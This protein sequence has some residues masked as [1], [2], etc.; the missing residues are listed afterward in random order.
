MK[1]SQKRGIII[2]A[3]IVVAVALVLILIPKEA[4]GSFGEWLCQCR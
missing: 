1:K 3:I 2:G 4:G